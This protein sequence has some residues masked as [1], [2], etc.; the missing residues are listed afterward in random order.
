MNPPH[1]K[2]LRELDLA[3]GRQGLRRTRVHLLQAMAKHIDVGFAYQVRL[4]D[5]NVIREADLAP[6][7]PVCV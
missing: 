4:A 1:V 6:R 7:F 3:E 5:E 2:H